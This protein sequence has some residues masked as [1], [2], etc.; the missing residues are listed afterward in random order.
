MRY[1]MMI[2]ATKDYEAGIPLSPELMAG[3]GKL[4]EEMMKAGV[5]LASDGLQP[6]S[7]GTRIKY[8]SGKRTVIDGP[9]AETKELIG[10]Y[11]ILQAKSKEE[12]IELANRVVEVHVKAGIPEFE[13]EIRPLFDPADF[14]PAKL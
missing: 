5:L 3:M 8:S 9:F 2:K 6:S 4:T 10:G 7:K 12:A 11:A 14:G 1:M 13:M